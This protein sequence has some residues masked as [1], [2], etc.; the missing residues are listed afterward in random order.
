M[1]CQEDQSFIKDISSKFVY[2]NDIII[3]PIG[4]IL[5]ALTL[6]VFARKK[7]CNTSMGFYN[8]LI[9]MTNFSLMI[10]GF[11]NHHNTGFN[12]ISDFTCISFAYSYRVILETSSWLNT[13]ISID[14]LIWVLYTNK[15]AFVK[16]KKCLHSATS[17]LFLALLLVNVP[18][19]FFKL[20][21]TQT[22]EYLI[23]NG[24]CENRTGVRI[25]CT[26]SSELV[27]WRD[28]IYFLS[29]N[30]LPYFLS[31]G[32][33][34]CLL[35]KLTMTKQKF[36]YAK[37]LRAEYHFAKSAAC[38]N[39]FFVV[40]LF[41]NVVVMSY[42][43]LFGIEETV[44]GD[45]ILDFVLLVSKYVAFYFNVFSFFVNYKFNSLF[46]RELINTI[47]SCV[48][49]ICLVCLRDRDELVERARSNKQFLNFK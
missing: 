21:S 26:A 39:L 33:S 22:I 49:L 36:C 11:I 41:P 46:K 5:N 45:T 43:Q 48:R 42:M 44:K 1:L 25:E 9:A 13:F 34:S 27:Y 24:S 40:C 8:Q 4:I 31:I 20:S 37:A 47:G 3:F 7:L 30:I 10:L 35:F 6:L 14:R 2:F 32:I 29:R 38:L 19:L 23:V 18:N 17:V 16:L 28:K 12:L 15:S